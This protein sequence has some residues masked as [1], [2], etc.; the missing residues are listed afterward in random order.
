MNKVVIKNLV[1]LSFIV[2]LIFGTIALIPFLSI[3]M[4]FAVMFLTAPV[5]ILYMIMDSKFDVDTLQ[6]TIIG[7]AIAGLSANISFAGVYTL[8]SSLLFIGFKYSDNYFLT[9]MIINSPL[10][11]TVIFII[12]IG[13]LTGTTNAFSGFVTYYM[14]NFLRDMYE[15][16][17][18]KNGNNNFSRYIK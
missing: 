8:I 7:G 15:K 2:G 10:W 13:V 6:K 4:L 5:V 14:V 1:I 12:F 9:T 17:Q 18:S 11:L 16:R 3:V